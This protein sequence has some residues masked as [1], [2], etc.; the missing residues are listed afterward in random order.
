MVW[1]KNSVLIKKYK[2][3]GII[4]TKLEFGKYNL[5]VKNNYRIGE[6]P[7]TKGVY[8]GNPSKFGSPAY[9][10]PILFFIMGILCFAYVIFMKLMLP[11][12]DSLV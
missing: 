10:L 2:L 9:L 3:W 7:I 5:V 1:M 6:M 8:I 11:Q 4:H 12:Y